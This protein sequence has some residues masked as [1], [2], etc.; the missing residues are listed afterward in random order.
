[1]LCVVY[2]GHEYSELSLNQVK[3]IYNIYIYYFV[4]P[5]MYAKTIFIYSQHQNKIKK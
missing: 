4:L 5:L 2:S 3:Y 1:M